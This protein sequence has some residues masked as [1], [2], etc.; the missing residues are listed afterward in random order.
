M[1]DSEIDNI[2]NQVSDEEESCSE[3]EDHVE[4]ADS[5]DS[6]SSESESA[7]VPAEGLF[8]KNGQI[9]YSE[10]PF[11]SSCG[12]TSRENIINMMPGLTRYSSSRIT[13]EEISS[14]ELF[15][16]PPLIHI[17]LNYTNIEG[18]RVFDKEW[19]DIDRSELFAFIWFTFVSGCVSI[20]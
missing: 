9:I 6:S 8:S 15:F 16:P 7:V 11:G 19:T 1:Q 10:T 12:R 2:L 5:S 18:R 17:I 20:K 3:F 13:D 4:N 14:F